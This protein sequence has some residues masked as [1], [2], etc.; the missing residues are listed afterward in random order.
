MALANPENTKMALIV[1]IVFY[2]IFS[3]VLVLTSLLLSFAIIIVVNTMYVIWN[4]SI[5]IAFSLIG[6]PLPVIGFA[7]ADLGWRK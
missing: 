4:T 5:A 3:F 6:T 7:M 1:I 2:L